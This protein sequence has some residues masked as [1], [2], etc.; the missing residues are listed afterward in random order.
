MESED[1]MLVP[2]HIRAAAE[3]VINDLLPKTSKN[4]YIRIYKAF[5]NFSENAF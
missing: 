4:I 5:T 1:E 2:K 3:S